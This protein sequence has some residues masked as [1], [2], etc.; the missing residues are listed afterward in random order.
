MPS[1]QLHGLRNCGFLSIIES[2][3]QPVH[4]HDLMAALGR[5]LAADPVQQQSWCCGEFHADMV[6]HARAAR[7]MQLTH[8]GDVSVIAALGRLPDLCG[9]EL[10]ALSVQPV[11]Y[12]PA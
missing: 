12:A 9:L 11:G 2:A 5:R 8:N 4:C 1:L 7:A 3:A 6:S 10:T